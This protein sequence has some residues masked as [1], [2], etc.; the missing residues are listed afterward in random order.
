VTGGL[1]PRGPAALSR[2]AG[3]PA[4]RASG[5]GVG[6]TPIALDWGQGSDVPDWADLPVAL[7]RTLSN[8]GLAPPADPVVL[9]IT[10]RRQV[11]R[12]GLARLMIHLD[13]ATDAKIVR[14]EAL[15][16]GPR[17]EA[18]PWA[19]EAQVVGLT[20]VRRRLLRQRVC[21]GAGSAA[22]SVAIG[23]NPVAVLPPAIAARIEDARQ[24]GRGLVAAI[25]DEDPVDG[26]HE[27][28]FAFA[29]EGAAALVVRA[30]RR[31]GRTAA[32]AFSPWSVT[33]A[34]GAVADRRVVRLGGQER[35]TP[36]LGG[37]ERP[38]LER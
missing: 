5:P 15:A 21:V 11:R 24:Q 23:T 38:A 3:A 28:V 18:G 13:W 32:L 22:P 26:A 30:E 12:D 14:L 2:P 20:N 33:V 34:E 19:V 6:S 9:W 35:R 8:A 29:D 17:P 25:L 10:Q 1:V 7:R 37:Q 36:Q 31:A 27:S 4:P 16:R